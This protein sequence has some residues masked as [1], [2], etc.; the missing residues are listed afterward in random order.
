M[1]YRLCCVRRETS[2]QCLCQV[3]GPQAS[4]A[5]PPLL[6]LDGLLLQAL[7]Q[8]LLQM[9]LLLLLRLLR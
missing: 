6:D 3:G 7:L 1:S 5:W 2:L 8:V 9:L 4:V